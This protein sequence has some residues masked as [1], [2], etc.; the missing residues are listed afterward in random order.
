M[1]LSRN[2]KIFIYV[3]LF[4][5][6]GTFNNKN[7]ENFNFIKLNQ[8]TVS[9]LN[10]SDNLKLMNSLDIL[11]FNTSV[12]TFTTSDSELLSTHFDQI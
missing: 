11:K 6:I 3:F 2:K 7:F 9:G 1:H 12:Q 4:F 10:N 5:L 8:I